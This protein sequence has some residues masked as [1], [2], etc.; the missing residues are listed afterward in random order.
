M[1]TRLLKITWNTLQ[2][3]PYKQLKIWQDTKA[4]YS[5]VGNI[6]KD[7][8]TTSNSETIRREKL[9]SMA[10]CVGTIIGDFGVNAILNLVWKLQSDGV[11]TIYV[12]I[13]WISSWH[14]PSCLV[15]VL[16]HKKIN[17]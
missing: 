10:R 15:L 6:K 4:I 13:V 8:F 1:T 11:D 2:G 14:Q 3:I 17:S 7:Q 5:N 16:L 12:H 9:I